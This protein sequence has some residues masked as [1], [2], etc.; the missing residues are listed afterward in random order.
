MS[1]PVAP[2][3]LVDE[4][5]IVERVL[6]QGGMGVVVAA[7]HV[8]LGYP[9]AIKFL[10]EE[11]LGSTD[12]VL[13]FEREARAVVRIQS[14]HVAKVLDVGKLATGA[15][16]IV[17]EL[18][19]GEDL[20]QLI[21]RDGPLPIHVAAT[22]ILEACGA[23]AEAHA[24]GIVHRDMKPANL[25][26]AHRTKGPKVTKVL[27]FG[28]S[29]SNGFGEAAAAGLTQTSTI[30]GSP[31][32]MS[33]EQL[34]ATRNV[35]A[36]SDVW[37]LGATLFEL[38]CGRPPFE[39]ESLADLVAAVLGAPTPSMGDFRVGVPLELDAI[40]RRCLEKDPAKRYGSISELAAALRPLADPEYRGE[41]VAPSGLA[42]SP[43]FAG[44][45]DFAATIST[46]ATLT[47]DA[48][49]E[50]APSRMPMRWVVAGS[51]L[52]TMAIG[53]VVLVLLTA[54]ARRALDTTT[55]TAAAGQAPA[56]SAAAPP[57]ETKI[58]PPPAAEV[59]P[60][61]ATQAIPPQAAAPQT[62]ATAASVP[63]R[64]ARPSSRTRGRTGAT[65]AGSTA[66]APQRNPLDMRPL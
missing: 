58:A 18:L 66:P 9:V 10:S 44:S 34:R 43:F 31:S 64:P 29:K 56:V 46:D 55:T 61:A 39:A 45:R 17:M 53:S 40:V 13:R 57:Q 1:V 8:Q 28:I 60:A 14:E 23:L 24:L 33:P 21:A 2:G 6:G 54:P 41:T 62:V 26:V 25:F 59:A 12:S 22:H 47:R 3:Q 20:G 4:K 63:A 5:F 27:D 42:R 7:R 36:R 38:V 52:A 32:Y 49:P 37:S 11:A 48:V 51:A 16:F 30:M 50:R 35:D 15:P 19:E 65:P